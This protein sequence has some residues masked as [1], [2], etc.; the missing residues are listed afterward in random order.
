MPLLNV[1]NKVRHGLFNGLGL[2]KLFA[3]VSSVL[4]LALA[5]LLILFKVKRLEHEK[6]KQQLVEAHDEIDKQTHVLSSQNKRTEID[7]S[8]VVADR[9]AIDDK[10][11]DVYRD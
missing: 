5:F 4:G 3:I 7:E 2:T 8:V 6:S 11:H 1:L 10:L 9:T